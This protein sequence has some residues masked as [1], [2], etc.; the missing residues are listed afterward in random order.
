[1]KHFSRVDRK[2]DHQRLTRTKC[3]SRLCVHY[4]VDT[5]RYVVPLFEEA[6]NHELTLSRFVHLHLI[7]HEISKANRAQIDNLQSHGIRTCHLMRYMVAQKGGYARVG[8]TKKD[9][10]NYFDRKM[11][12]TIKDGDVVA[13]LNYLNVKSSVDPMLY[14]KYY[15]NS[16]GRIK[17][18]FWADGSSR[19]DYFCFWR[20]GCVRHK[21]QEEQ[22][23]LPISYI[24]RV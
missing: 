19:S 20:C 17:S 7:Y 21:L 22:I 4:K 11:C 12:A 2:R 15:V 6:H 9:L 5:N 10:Y 3:I 8:F 23:Q 18:L 13:A 16:N 24:F 1:M 14:A